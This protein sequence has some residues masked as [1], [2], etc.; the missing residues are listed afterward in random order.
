[1]FKIVSVL[2]CSIG[3]GRKGFMP[4]LKTLVLNKY[5]HFQWK[6]KFGFPILFFMLI[7]KL[8]CISGADILVY[9]NMGGKEYK[10]Y[11]YVSLR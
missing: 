4:I 5:K 10:F 2:L 8:P 6:F 3:T 11:K 1:M 7:V 9:M